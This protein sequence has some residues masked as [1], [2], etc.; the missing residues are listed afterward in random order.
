MKKLLVLLIITLTL[1]GCRSIPEVTPEQH[2]QIV[3]YSASL[4]L[5]YDRF[6]ETNLTVIE[7]PAKEPEIIVVP[8]TSPETENDQGILIPET[9]EI[10]DN[11][12]PQDLTGLVGISG[13]EFQYSGTLVTD[14][15]PE[16][17]GEIAFG[18]DAS[19]GHNLLV[20]GFNV[21]NTSGA[22]IFLDMYGL[23]L[24]IMIGYNGGNL[25]SSLFTMLFDDLAFFQ[26][27][28]PAGEAV[29]LS[30]LREANIT[31]ISEIQSI[32][33]LIRADSGDFSFSY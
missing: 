7:L 11:T 28:I 30:S 5:K 3:E 4:L 2:A 8:E 24:R 22:D 19:P 9:P 1:T 14:R 16:D 21:V 26:G 31:D 15:Y 32:D 12:I 33:F 6:Y 23:D 18:I 10:I 17:S 29:A 13:L 25:S 20:V 27:V